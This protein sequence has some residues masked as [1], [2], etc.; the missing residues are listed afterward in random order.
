MSIKK[1][2][3]FGVIAFLGA[4]SSVAVFFYLNNHK[5]YSF[6]VPNGENDFSVLEYG[7]QPALGNENYF[8]K[9]HDQFV[10]EKINFIEAD[11]TNM[12]IRLYEAGALS[13]EFKIKAKGKEGT[14]WET[15]AGVYKIE[16]K[17][18][19]HFSSF[20]GVYQ[21][22]SMQFQGN[23]FIHGWPYYPD[24]TPV[25]STYSGGCVRLSVED[26]EKIYDWA[27]IGTPVLVFEKDFDGDGF[28]YAKKM[29]DIS[30]ESY[31]AADLKNNFAFFEKDSERV[32]SAVP[33]SRLISALVS[34]EYINLEKKISITEGMLSANAGKL[35]AGQ[36][37]S[38]YNLL[39]LALG[40]S[41]DSAGKALSYF[42][43]E[44]RFVE[45]M[46]AKAKAIGMSSA[47]FVDASGSSPK[48]VATASDLFVLARYLYNNR[49]FI[50][51]I[52]AGK[53]NLSAYGEPAI[54]KIRNKNEFLGDPEFLGG[55][56]FPVETVLPP[57]ASGGEIED[58]E[59]PAE[60]KEKVSALA[61]FEMEVNGEKRPVG[62]IVMGSDNGKSD[63]SAIY[64]W[65][66]SEY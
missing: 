23:F 9:I 63:V 47:N 19:S 50:L 30:A 51:K 31:L 55:I 58:S 61:V 57:D 3:I 44:K 15:P 29:P 39:H 64:D 4:A 8:K 34:T 26:S 16:T 22:W 38:A 54:G 56:V 43:G 40:E 32:S 18:K 24:G 28:K 10:S 60:Q 21:P 33:V 62:I 20:A 52:T 17:E 36:T 46:N 65:I 35:Y 2:I 11:L 49:S 41:S 12:D 59:A 37:I 1:K 25:A 42:V 6:L 14:W 5:N 7:A 48:N 45:L 66:K 53:S 13:Q 27:E